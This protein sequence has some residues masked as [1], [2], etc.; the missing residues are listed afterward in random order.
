MPPIIAAVVQ[1]VI[2]CRPRGQHRP[3]II[4]AEQLVGGALHEEQILEIGAD[5]AENAED[6]L[7]EDRRLEQAAIE[8]M[9]EIVEMADVVALV[10]ELRAVSFAEQS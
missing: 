4:L 3:P 9:G 6:Q 8:A 5:A 1:K 2:W 10:L 7:Q